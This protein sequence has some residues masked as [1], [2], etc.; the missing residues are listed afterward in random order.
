MHTAY[1]FLDIEKAF[2]YVGHDGLLYKMLKIKILVTISKIIESFLLNKIFSVKWI[3][4]LL[5]ESSS[6]DTIL[7]RIS[8]P[9]FTWIN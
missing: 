7:S 4:L 1:V 2:D 5:Y 3:L 9:V 6:H 8:I